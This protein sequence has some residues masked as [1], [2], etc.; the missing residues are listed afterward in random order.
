[1]ARHQVAVFPSSHGL[2]NELQG[3]MPPLRRSLLANEA[4]PQTQTLKAAFV[5]TDVSPEGANALCSNTFQ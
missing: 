2:T 3:L 4:F 1:M 5:T